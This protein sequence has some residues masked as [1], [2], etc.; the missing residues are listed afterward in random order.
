MNF[1]NKGFTLIEIIIAMTLIAI[2]VTLPVLA[3]ANFSKSSRDTQRRN[4]INKVQAALEQYKAQ[5]SHYPD[6]DTWEEDLVNGGYI[7]EIPQDPKDGQS[8]GDDSAL[9]YQYTYSVSEDS[10]SYQLAA[11]LELTPA[12]NGLSS[13]PPPGEGDFYVATPAGTKHVRLPGD[14]SGKFPEPTQMALPT[15]PISTRTPTP[16]NAA[17]TPSASPT[18]TQPIDL[19][20]TS[21]T[22]DATEYTIT[23]CNNGTASTSN[24]T[25]IELRRLLSPEGSGP[26]WN[27]TGSLPVPAP[28]Q[29]ATHTVERCF[30]TEFGGACSDQITVRATVNFYNFEVQESNYINNSFDQAFS[31]D[32]P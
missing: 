12:G 16:T 2:F 11:L 31:A 27:R 7:P 22:R 3:Y 18:P 17:G 15:S 10:A 29:C 26:G 19:V 32:S 13:P 6:N 24:T 5:N 21:V 4:D 30:S 14:E 1:G 9:T 28:S 20:V 23:Y 8:T 25:T